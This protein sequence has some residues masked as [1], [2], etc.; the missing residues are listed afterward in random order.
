L[1]DDEGFAH[2]R[3]ELALQGLASASH[4]AMSLQVLSVLHAADNECLEGKSIFLLERVN[5]FVGQAR[6]SDRAFAW[7]IRKNNDLVSDFSLFRR[8]PNRI[9]FSRNL[10]QGYFVARTIAYVALQLCYQLG[11]PKVLMVGFD[12][13][14][15]KG[16]FYEASEECLKSSLDEDYDKYIMPCFRLMSRYIVESPRFQVF[17]LS[18]D[19]RLPHY[20]VPKIS[21][22]DIDKV[23]FG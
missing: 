8:A 11:S 6:M 23:L 7:S 22:S 3:C 20:I 14:S 1:C 16:R 2:N 12:L 17:N 19:S 21:I 18:A 15:G 9:G 13:S 10:D 4:V 5:R